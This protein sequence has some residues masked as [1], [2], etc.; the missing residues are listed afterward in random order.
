MKSTCL[1]MTTLLAAAAAQGQFVFDEG[2]LGDFSTDPAAGTVL[3]FGLGTN[4]VLGTMGNSN[5][6]NSDFSNPN[7]DRDFFTFTVGAGQSVTSIELTEWSVANQGFIAIDD[8]FGSVIPGLTTN[9]DLLSGILVSTNDL[10]ANLLDEFT[11][12]AV[13]TNSLPSPILGPGTYTFVVQQTTNLT[14]AYGL[15]FTLVP[16]PAAAAMLGGGLLAV[17]R[18]RG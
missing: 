12:G 1:A 2:T 11:T 14:Q 8:G 15:R 5:A 10:G 7:G 6:V 17:R 4:T 16:S 13:T 9:S 18:R 3:G